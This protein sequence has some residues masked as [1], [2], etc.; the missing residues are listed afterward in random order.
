VKRHKP[1]SPQEQRRR[2]KRK[3]ERAF[4]F[5]PAGQLLAG[6]DRDTWECALS[7]ARG[8]V[9]SAAEACGLR[10][11]PKGAKAL[12]GRSA[13]EAWSTYRHWQ[14]RRRAE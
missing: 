6:V 1:K 8:D 5:T 12:W 14:H 13:E 10:A 3:N 11:L 9:A 2:R 7:V 4:L